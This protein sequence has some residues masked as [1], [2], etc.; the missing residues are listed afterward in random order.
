MKRISIVLFILIL[1]FTL[2]YL[3]RRLSNDITMEEYEF[4][5][6]FYNNL[7]DNLDSLHFNNFVILDSTY[8]RYELTDSLLVHLQE[9]M[10]TAFPQYLIEDFRKKNN[11][12][13]KINR[14]L[15][16]DLEYHL[17]NK[18]K[19]NRIFHDGSWIEFYEVFPNSQGKNQISRVGFNNRM[20]KALLYFD[21]RSGGLSGAGYFIFLVKED[22][23]WKPF[24]WKRMWVS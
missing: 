21:T 15:D 19:I 4:Y 16:I 9:S 7:I 24:R 3:C 12:P 2:L 18:K 1:T 10:N 23:K 17:I 5:S 13:Y 11:K 20:T 8:C 14:F 6:D 22:G